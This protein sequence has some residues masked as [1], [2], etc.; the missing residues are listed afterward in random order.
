MSWERVNQMLQIMSN[1]G[2][3]LGLVLVAAQMNQTT[4]A[5][6]LQNYQSTMSGFVGLD[7]AA[8]GDTGYAAHTAALLHPAE[9]TEEEIVQYWYF[10]DAVMTLAVSQWLAVQSG[11]ATE[12][13][14]SESRRELCS[15]L[16]H[17][18]AR[19]IWDSYKSSGFPQRFIDE[20]DAEFSRLPRQGMV[21]AFQTVVGKVRALQR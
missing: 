4:D 8:V 5:I 16:N 2:V 15:S 19:I 20:I 6:R 7:L 9:M 12:S 13:D 3:V 11:Q 14:W 1:V 21:R 17:P 10:V 18:V